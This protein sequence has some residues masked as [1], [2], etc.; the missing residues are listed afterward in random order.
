MKNW[1]GLSIIAIG[2]IHT[3]FGIVFLY[4]VLLELWQEGLFNTVHGEPMREACFWFLF[5]G[6][7]MMLIGALVHWIEKQVLL[8]PRFLGWSL[9]AIGLGV[10][11]IM[12]V[13]GG[14]LLFVPTFG[15]LLRK[16][17]KTALR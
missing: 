10:V 14:W 6:F 16:R 11:L 13:S 17:S 1:I 4:P 9:L 5:A 3:I 15:A 2:I 12:P 8:L 7:A